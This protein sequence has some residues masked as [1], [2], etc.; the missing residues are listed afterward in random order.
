M[1]FRLVPF[2]ATEVGHASRRGRPGCLGGGRGRGGGG[3][4]AGLDIP[5][6]GAERRHAEEEGRGDEGR[7]RDGE[8]QPAAPHPGQHTH[9]LAQPQAGQRLKARRHR[10]VQRQLLDGVLGVD[11]QEA[12]VEADEAAHVD[13]RGQH[14]E[15]VG[16]DRIEVAV[17]DSRFLG[18]L[19][20]R[21][22]GL[23]TARAQPPA[24]RVRSGL[25]VGVDAVRRGLIAPL[26]VPVRAATPTA[27]HRYKPSTPGNSTRDFSP[28]IASLEAYACGACSIP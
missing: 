1:L 17:A 5:A 4:A 11:A 7:R 2:D 28:S 24:E 13:G 25:I 12:R 6:N 15:A 9:A 8:Q 23:Q 22:A 16:L 14:V 18:S 26:R 21:E 27:Q 10:Q 20:Q 3:A 19:F